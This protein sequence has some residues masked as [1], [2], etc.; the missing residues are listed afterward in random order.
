MLTTATSNLSAIVFRQDL[1]GKAMLPFDP[2][3]ER[4]FWRDMRLQY[5]VNDEPRVLEKEQELPG[6][7]HIYHR[8]YAG[9]LL[10]DLVSGY[11][12]GLWNELRPTTDK[13]LAWMESTP[14][15][16]RA[17]YLLLALTSDGI[18]DALTDWRP[19]LG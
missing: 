12:V 15:P 8:S 2:V 14:Q 4:A 9:G 19:V 10:T 11:L 17:G 16:D 1:G 7:T 13:F 6:L 5:V 18:R 3:G